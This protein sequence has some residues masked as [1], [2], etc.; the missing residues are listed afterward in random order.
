[1]LD[2]LNLRQ[3]T[4][5]NRIEAKKA[6]GGFP[7]SVWETYS[8]FCNTMGGVILLGVEERKDH[9]LHA[10]TVPHPEEL[11]A[12]FWQGLEE[13]K[14]SANV[15]SFDQVRLEEVDGKQI[16]VITVPRAPAR[17]LPVYV[18]DSPYTGSYRRNG[19]GDYKCSRSQV[20]K[21]L[22]AKKK[23][24]KRVPLFAQM[25]AVV[26]FLTVCASASRK[27]I[28][29]A[30]GFSPAKLKQILTL[31]MRREIVVAEGKT[32]NRVYKLKR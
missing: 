23:S 7:Q 13:E 1:M 15:L 24:K 18:G 20:Q 22:G 14:V 16:V 4:E 6:V 26:E 31:L 8:A 9:S 17:N 3:Y 2:Y 19:D 27:E 11:I 25:Q 29:E 12:E 10:V 30:L 5:N 21:M 32:R 28:S